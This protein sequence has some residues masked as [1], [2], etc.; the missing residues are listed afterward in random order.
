VSNYPHLF[1]P[2]R[3]GGHMLPNR[4][5]HASTSTHYAQGGRVTARLIDYYVNR[6]RGGAA[7]LVSEPMGMLHWQTLPTRPDVLSGANA[8]ML[9][10]WAEAV[11]QE[12]GLMLGQVQDNGRGFR[13]GH[14]NLAARGASPLPDDLSWTIPEALGTPDIH[15]MIDEFVESCAKLAAAG[16]AGAEISAG[17]GHLFHQFL[18]PRSNQREDVFGGDR[19]G[20]TLLLRLLMRGIR[21]RCGSDFLIGAKLPAWDGTEGGIDLAEAEAITRLLHAE[22]TMD[23]LTYC[24]GSH[25]ETLYTHLPDNHGPRTPY[26]ADIERLG[27]AGAPGVPL[28]ALGLITDPNEGERL[29]REGM[30]DLVML[31]RPLVTDPA[32]PRKAREG[33]EAEIRYCVSCNTCWGMITTGRGLLCDNNPRVGAPDEADWRVPAAPR[34]RRVVVVG[35]GIAGMEAAWVAAARGHDVHLLGASDEPGGKTRMHALLPGGEGLSSIYDYQQLAARRQGVKMVLGRRADAGDIL[36]LSPDVVI[37]ATGSTPSWP[38]FL[39]AGWREEG[40]IPDLREAIRLLADHPGRHSGTAVLWDEDHGAFTY[41]AAEFLMQRF[42]RVAI[43][44]PR[45]RLASDESLVVRQGVYHRLYRGGATILTS[46]RPL[47]DPRIAEGEVAYANIFSG[48]RSVVTDV[49]FLTFATPRRPDDGLDAPLRAAGIDV[50]RIGDCKAP[51][52]ALTATG[53]GY[54]AAMDI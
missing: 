28:G 19:E 29:I 51:R 20:R 21:E 37:L 41:D 4:I 14:R 13:A 48:A 17:H 3:V 44:T 30:A 5:V 39:P 47:P 43:L 38:D 35:A 11:A 26:V 9:S 46:V 23:Y 8:D 24:W 22:G 10:R 42:E 45:E 34:P 6:A 40:L 49:A 54:R 15:Q 27:R 25:S 12:G 50:R 53:E 36:G 1:S 16:F 2:V 33:R 7:M 32:W 52:I 18:S 31:A